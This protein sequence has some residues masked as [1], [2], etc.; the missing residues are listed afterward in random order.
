MNFDLVLANVRE[1][2]ILA[3]EGESYVKPVPGGAQLA[4]HSP[5]PL[6]LYSNGIVMF[7]GP[8]RSYDEPSTQVGKIDLAEIREINAT[9]NI[10]CP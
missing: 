3:G 7:S 6:Q 2:N 8:F 5:I 4:R 9:A 10:S 1:L